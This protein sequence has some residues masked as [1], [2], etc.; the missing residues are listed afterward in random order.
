MLSKRNSVWIDIAV[1]AAVLAFFLYSAQRLTHKKPI[2]NS[3]KA[4]MME[5]LRVLAERVPASQT[6]P[7]E[8]NSVNVLELGCLP[9][10]GKSYATKSRLLR[11]SA[12]LCEKRKQRILESSGMNETNGFDIACFIDPKT[13]KIATNFFQ[14]DPGK[15]RI[16]LKLQMANG[17]RREEQLEVIRE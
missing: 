13:Q 1:F 5:D 15:N 8:D 4:A 12:S 2:A 16:Q 14:L 3:E 11:I 6:I 10:K 9:A 7:A 17:Q